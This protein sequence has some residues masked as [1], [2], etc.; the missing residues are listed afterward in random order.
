VDHLGDFLQEALT[1]T[2]GEGIPSGPQWIDRQTQLIRRH[3]PVMQAFGD[4][5]AAL[6]IPRLLQFNGGLIEIHS[7]Q[8][9]LPYINPWKNA[10]R[11]LEIGV[12]AKESGQEQPDGSKRSREQ[13]ERSQIFGSFPA[14]RA[15]WIGGRRPRWVWVWI[16]GTV[17]DLH[18][19]VTNPMIQFPENSLSSS[20]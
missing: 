8:V 10:V 5:Q 16:W 12:I 3:T 18:E 1:V 6:Q 17:L 19:R 15:R 14:V 20:Y 9:H 7:A 11:D 13:Y 4:N 2:D